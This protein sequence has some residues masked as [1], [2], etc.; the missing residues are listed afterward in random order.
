MDRLLPHLPVTLLADIALAVILIEALV[1][2]L[3]ARKAGAG[4]RA[5]RRCLP[6]LAAGVC[7]MLAI[8][9]V[10]RDAAWWWVAAALA[11]G[12]VA[13]LLDL[14]LRWRGD[15]VSSDRRTGGAVSDRTPPDA[16]ARRS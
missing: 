16:S 5:A 13:H 6:T 1:L 9:A 14:R 10:A 15:A 11:A 4:G 12:G 8:A 7:L 3:L 2:A